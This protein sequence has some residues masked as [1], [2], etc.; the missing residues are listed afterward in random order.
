MT[1]ARS[2]YSVPR[3][4]RG[5]PAT[6]WQVVRQRLFQVDPERQLAYRVEVRGAAC[7]DI[8][9]FHDDATA[10]KFGL[11]NPMVETISR[12]KGGCVVYR[13]VPPP[14]KLV[15]RLETFNQLIRERRGLA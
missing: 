13:R 5:V 4:S 12:M 6:R 15:K 14:N 10:R 9:Y 8:H 2:W 1:S 7:A 11:K 3:D